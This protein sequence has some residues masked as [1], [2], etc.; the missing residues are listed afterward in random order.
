MKKLS[1]ILI[2]ISASITKAEP[3]LDARDEWLRADIELLANEG[4]IKAPVT[5]WPVPWASIIRDLDA[6]SETKV[7]VELLPILLRVKRKARFETE[8]ETHKFLSVKGGNQ[9]KIIRH[10]G[11]ERREK[12][13]VSTRFTGVSKSFAWNV[14]ATKAFDPLDGEEERF[15]HSYIA[16]IWGNWIISAGAQERWYGPGWDSS[17]IL[18]N[19]ARPIPGI[20]IQRNYSDPFDNPWLSWI[21]PW[22]INAFAGQLESNRFIPH[23]KLLGMSVSFK[24]FNSLEI[25][26]RRTAQWGGEGRP[27]SLSSL[28]DLAIGRTNCDQIED[29]CDDRLNG[30]EAG[31]QLAGIDFNWRLPTNNYMGSLYGQLVGE[32]EAGYAPSRK[33]YQLGYKTNF[34]IGGFGITTYL[35][36]ADTENEFRPNLTYEHGIYQT[37]YRAEG[38]SIGSTYDNDTKSMSVGFLATHKYGDRY[39]LRIAKVDLNKDGTG[40]HTVSQAATSFT[41]LELKYQHPTKYGLLGIE[42]DVKDKS[43]DT[44]GYQQDKYNIGISWSMEL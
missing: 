26:L 34:L 9:S 11:D 15:D 17:L 23:A 2:L 28:V 6:A 44:L 40:N 24:P 3:W 10:F 36:Y 25:G 33:F 7:S 14:E 18:S 30:N 22:T 1:I 39:K 8:N 35:E 41:Q 4:I 20:S 12:A 13:E 21:G 29:G 5:T 32:D 31:N 37:G 42:L 38:R 16:A 27:E 43:V 19:N